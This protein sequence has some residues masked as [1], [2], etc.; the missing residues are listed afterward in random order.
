MYK[1]MATEE[2]FTKVFVTGGML[3]GLGFALNGYDTK[4]SLVPQAAMAVPLVIV[5]G[6]LGHVFA[7]NISPNF[8]ALVGCISCVTLG[9]MVAKKYYIDNFQSSDSQ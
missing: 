1:K 6:L 2:N 8:G 5:S 4:S 9:C 3:C 7:K